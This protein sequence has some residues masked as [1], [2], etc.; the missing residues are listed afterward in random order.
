LRARPVVPV[1]S[2]LNFNPIQTR[3]KKF[4]V[5]ITFLFFCVRLDLYSYINIF[6]FD[7]GL[8][9]ELKSVL[10][11]VIEEECQNKLKDVNNN[12][13]RFQELL[14]KVSRQKKFHLTLWAVGED[15]HLGVEKDL[16]LLE[17]A[18]LII[19]EMGYS[20]QSGYREYTLTDK[21][22]RLVQ[23]LLNQS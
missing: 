3:R 13:G 16:D 1:L 21:G 14:L 23:K 11:E 2:G 15:T 9:S 7:V 5:G 18:D 4:G 10:V 6:V 8:S 12:L 17:K 19:G 20:D 22:N